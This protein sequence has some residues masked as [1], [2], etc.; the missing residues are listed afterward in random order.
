[1]QPYQKWSYDENYILLYNFYLHT[2]FNYK[3]LSKLS[4][5]ELF[6]LSVIG[7]IMFHYP[8]SFYLNKNDMI[9]LFQSNGWTFDNSKY[10]SYALNISSKLSRF[11][12]FTKHKYGFDSDFLIIFGYLLSVYWEQYLH[13]F[14]NYKFG[15]NLNDI[16]DLGE[17][18]MSI[19]KNKLNN[20]AFNNYD[21]I[22]SNWENSVT[23]NE[24]LYIANSNRFNLEKKGTL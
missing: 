14:K 18:M 2:D 10:S 19:A 3:Y 6:D 21:Y 24:F 17:K 7:T 20:P 11:F 1:M 15:Y 4:K 23:K 22:K 13:Y 12:N 8:L 16:T 9:K 5:W